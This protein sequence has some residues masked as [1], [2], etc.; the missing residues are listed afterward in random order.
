MCGLFGFCVINFCWLNFCGVFGKLLC[1]LL[2]FIKIVLSFCNGKFIL[3][4]EIREDI[5]VS[6]MY[7]NNR[8]R[9]DSKLSILFYQDDGLKVVCLVLGIL[10]SD[11]L[12]GEMSCGVVEGDKLSY[13]NCIYL[14]YEN[15]LGVCQMMYFVVVGGVFSNS[16]IEGKIYYC[17]FESEVQS[18][19]DSGFRE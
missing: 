12:G 14:G 19:E 6:M 18:S 8:S 7:L 13:N 1:G 3:F 11:F 10:S 9:V 4:V 16:Y 17:L 15:I 2:L 5:L